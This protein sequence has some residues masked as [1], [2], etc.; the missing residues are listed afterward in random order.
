MVAQYDEFRNPTD[1]W[2]VLDNEIRPAIACVIT[3]ALDPYQ[4][5]TTP[6]VRTRE[7]RFGQTGAPWLGQLDEGT[8]AERFW[9]SGGM[10]RSDRPLDA[11]QVHLTLV[12]RDLEVSL[13]PDGRFAIGGLKAGDYTLEV[14]VEGRK[15]RRFSIAVPAADYELKV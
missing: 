3:L 6:L 4:P 5:I 13:Q 15:P 9:T 10:V 7:I 12:E 11:L 8:E 14:A 2:N 1:V